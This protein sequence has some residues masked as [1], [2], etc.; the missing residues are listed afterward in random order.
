MSASLT[1]YLDPA[2]GLLGI[3]TVLATD[4]EVGSDGRL[5]AIN[6]EAGYRGIT[7]FVVGVTVAALSGAR[8][9]GTPMKPPL[10]IQ[11]CR[12]LVVAVQAEPAL[13][14]T[15]ERRVA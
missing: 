6:P 14:V 15:G 4:L 12:N 3:G 11:V 2:A 5:W 1:A 13:L 8:R 9:F 10:R 7:A